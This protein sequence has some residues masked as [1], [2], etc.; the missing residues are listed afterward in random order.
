MPIRETAEQRKIRLEKERLAKEAMGPKLDEPT[1]P[2]TILQRPN[3][4]EP[5]G[6]EPNGTKPKPKSRL[7][8]SG[9]ALSKGLGGAA[10]ALTIGAGPPP[11]MVAPAGTVAKGP[12]AHVDPE[13]RARELRKKLSGRGFKKG[14]SVKSRDGVAIRG[15][16]RGRFV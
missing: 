5:N 9:E 6:D 12:L 4:D 15:K 10:S 8:K 2:G 11:Q 14:G 13:M 3:G 7:E 1:T 16:T